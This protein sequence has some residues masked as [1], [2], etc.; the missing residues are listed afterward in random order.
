M[1]TTRD[2]NA[3]MVQQ[4]IE[5]KQRSGDQEGAAAKAVDERK[6]EKARAIVAD[7]RRPWRGAVKHKG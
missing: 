4:M 2:E 1:G 5:A 6:Q 7:A 3:E